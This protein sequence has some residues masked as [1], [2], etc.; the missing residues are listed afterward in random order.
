MER[1]RQVYGLDILVETGTFLGD[2]V[3]HFKNRFGRLYSIELQADL[4]QKAAARFA[5]DVN[6]SIIEGNSGAILETLVPSLSRPALFWLDGHYSS[7]F[8]MGDMYVTTARG[9]TDTPI[10]RELEAVV[11]S[12]LP[13]VVLIDDARLFGLAE[14]YP[15]LSEI[16]CIVKTGSVRR[17]V[18]VENDMI[19]VLPASDA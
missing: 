19:F 11:R 18:S 5:G 1:L 10:D 6:V 9:E 7:D 14:H 4:F 8:L 16:K 17:T 15:A 13:H 2:T 3:E 12:T